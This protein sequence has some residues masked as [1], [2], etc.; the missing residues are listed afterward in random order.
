MNKEIVIPEG[1]EARIKGN[2]VIFELKESED[3]KIRKE[4]VHF[5]QKEKE[6]M[7]SKVELEN[8]P[9]LRFLMD[10][11]DYLEKKR[12]STWTEEDDTFERN[13]LPRILNPSGWTLEQNNADK[14]YLEE[15][16][17]RQKNKSLKNQIG[18]KL[19]LIQW[20]GKNLKEVIA[21]TGKSPRFDEWFKSWEDFEN[22]V[23]SHGDILKLF[24]ED[25]SH[26]EVPVG[27]WIVKTPDGFSVPS[28]F[29]FVQKSPEWSEEDEEMLRIIINRVEKFNEW[30]TERGY[31]LDDPTL[32]QKPTDWLKA[33][34][35]H[36]KPSEEQMEWLESA[37][38]LSTDKPS[39]HGII[40]SLYEQLKK[41]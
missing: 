19:A 10:A 35:P 26:Y 34:N 31:P 38:R 22:Y 15:F 18:Q 37:V 33:L 4:L 12:E 7:E 20:T 14:H 39:I 23:H 27:A 13:I 32:K 1:Y 17:D 21:F 6:Y 16:V 41:L 29:N 28:L 24:C 25:G 5:I 30:A 36:W 8:S 9:K 40:V 11:L 3:E 2:K